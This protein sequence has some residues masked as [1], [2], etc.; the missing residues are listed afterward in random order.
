MVWWLTSIILLFGKLRQ[1]D[2]EFE[3]SFKYSVISKEKEVYL[4][5]KQTNK[6]K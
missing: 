6:P 1:K 5:N 3:V 4:K 2:R